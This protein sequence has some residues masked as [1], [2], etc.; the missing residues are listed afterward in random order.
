MSET[1][2]AADADKAPV[3]AVEG[4]YSVGTLSYTKAG[5]ITLFV[6]LLWG[7]FCFTLM[8]S[9]M[10]V[11]MPL[12]MKEVGS[13]ATFMAVLLG[14]VP[15]AINFVINPIVSFRSDRYRSRL[16]RRMPFLLW[17]TPPLAIFLILIGYTDH[18]GAAL[19]VPLKASFPALTAVSVALAVLAVLYTGFQMAH[20]VVGSI[21][22][23][24]FNDVVPTAVMA[25][26]M[27]LFR[28]VGVG[29]GSLFSFLAVP[30]AE[31]HSKLIFT[32][33]G[34]LY[35]IGVMAMCLKVKEGQ[36][37]PPPEIDRS[38]D[39]FAEAKTYL[40]EC[41]T[42]RFYWYF[43]LH[44][45]TAAMSYQCGIFN[46]LRLKDSVGITLGEMGTIGGIS[47]IISLCLLY[48]AGLLADRLNPIRV[49]VVTAILV[50]FLVPIQIVWLF[51]DF[52]HRTN[53]LIFAG[54]GLAMLPLLVLQGCAEF[55]MQMRIL[56]K[57]RFG[58]FS[59]ANAMIRA[60][61]VMGTSV[62]AGLFIDLMRRVHHGSDFCY[63]YQPVWQT[64]FGTISIIFLILL[65]REWRHLGGNAGYVPPSVNV[66]GS[67]A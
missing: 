23:Y 28:M 31:S 32:V 1:L 33:S 25:Q 55:P 4:R 8:E 60:I 24:V 39:F 22:Y 30:Y 11:M 2:P 34:I 50:Y 36:Y 48:P 51:Y 19:L 6:W 42:H 18:F 14:F 63:R 38:K 44:S 47:S 12:K 3:M 13:S 45:A 29:A 58:Q 62:L 59:S 10:P 57:D 7:D 15:S 37:P 66:E 5:L 61:G 35:F 52:S 46:I 40:R 43:F 56:P 53:F 21:Y 64:F 49:Y 65:Y 16:G 41:F 54:L 26:F 9:V 20:M 67:H 27:S 17:A